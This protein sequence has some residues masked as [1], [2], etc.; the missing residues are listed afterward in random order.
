MSTATEMSRRGFLAG[1]SK[2][3]LVSAGALLLKPKGADAAGPGVPWTCMSQPQRNAWL[4]ETARGH[5]NKYEAYRDQCKGFVRTMVEQASV[6]GGDPMLTI[7]TTSAD[8]WHWEYNSRTPRLGLNIRWASAGNVIQMLWRRRDTG[9][10]TQHT[11]IVSYVS[12]YHFYVID[13]NWPRQPGD[14]NWTQEH[15]WFFS[16]FDSGVTINGTP[17]YSIYEMR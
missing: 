5:V 13:N 2:A 9:S 11:A 15:Y 14:Q 16:E 6:Y 10:I 4:V 3:A 17:C 1:L 8:G 7:P 12:T